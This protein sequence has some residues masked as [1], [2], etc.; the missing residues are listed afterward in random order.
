MI[1]FAAT[2]LLVLNAASCAQG[3]ARPYYSDWQDVYAKDADSCP[4]NFIPIVRAYERQDGR[5][6]EAGYLCQSLYRGRP[7]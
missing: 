2:M 3:E 6:V 4:T 1:R 5:W 7:K